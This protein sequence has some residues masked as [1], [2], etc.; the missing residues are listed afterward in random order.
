MRGRV[1]VAA[2]VKAEVG[3]GG[4]SEVAAD[5]EAEAGWRMG[6]TG[7]SFHPIG[8]ARVHAYCCRSLHGNSPTTVEPLTTTTER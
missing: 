2:D 5:M 1:E 8:Q 7:R 4:V 3:V 6:W